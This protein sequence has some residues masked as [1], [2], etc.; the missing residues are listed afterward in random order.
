MVNFT[1]ENL[2]EE[3]V[4]F[5]GDPS[6]IHIIQYKETTERR[7]RAIFCTEEYMY[8]IGARESDDINDGYLGCILSCRKVKPG[9]YWLRNEDYPEGKLSLETWNDIKEKI[10]VDI[11][12]LPPKD[13]FSTSATNSDESIF[14]TVDLLV[15]SILGAYRAID[16]LVGVGSMFYNRNILEKYSSRTKEVLLNILKDMPEEHH[17]IF[18]VCDNPILREVFK[19][20]GDNLYGEK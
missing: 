20:L 6:K 2:C 3:I 8:E 19:E 4:K 7:L 5:V 16:V 10:Q 12:E 14:A 13:V 15:K 11:F 17:P 1:L 9:E 18:L